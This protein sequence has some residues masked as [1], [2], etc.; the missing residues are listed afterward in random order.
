MNIRQFQP[1]E[2]RCHSLAIDGSKIYMIGGYVGRKSSD[3][4]W[5]LDINPGFTG[6]SFRLKSNLFS[7][8]NLPEKLYNPQK[9]DLHWIKI[10]HNLPKAIFFH[11]SV[12][13]SEYGEIFVF[14]GNSDSGKRNNKLSRFRVQPARLEKISQ[15]A[16]DRYCE[17]K[18][19]C[20]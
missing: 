18:I 11:D 3:S 6:F 20:F 17:K 7:T 5:K 14:G 13:N 8:E 19:T 4:I 1:P 12:F 9:L 15:K 2:V 16:K 10:R